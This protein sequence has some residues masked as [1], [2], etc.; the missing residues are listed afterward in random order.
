MASVV[1]G[2]PPMRSTAV[3]KKAG[4]GFERPTSSA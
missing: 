1:S 3:A 2:R 4:S